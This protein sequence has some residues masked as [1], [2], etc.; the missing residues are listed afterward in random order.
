MVFPLNVPRESMTSL[1]SLGTRALI[2]LD[3]G[4]PWWPHLTLITFLEIR[5]HTEPH[6]GL[7]LQPM[8]FG[9]HRCSVHNKSW[10]KNIPR[11]LKEEL[12]QFWP[13]SFLILLPFLVGLFPEPQCF[14]LP[15]LQGFLQQIQTIHIFLFLLRKYPGI[16]F[17]FAIII[18]LTKQLLIT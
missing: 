14:L 6:W 12:Y 8:N 4:L 11:P 2:P 1:V 15:N 7:E 17:Q 16:C 13:Y 18:V 3:Q 5:L 9:G 10:N